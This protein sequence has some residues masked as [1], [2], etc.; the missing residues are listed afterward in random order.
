MSSREQQ[1]QVIGLCSRHL[2]SHLASPCMSH[3]KNM[4]FCSISYQQALKNFN[5]GCDLKHCGN[6][7]CFWQHPGEAWLGRQCCPPKPDG[8]SQQP[9]GKW[10]SWDSLSVQY[11][12][13]C[14][15]GQ[16]VSYF[17]H[18]IPIKTGVRVVEDWRAIHGMG[19]RPRKNSWG[20]YLTYQRGPIFQHPSVH[21]WHTHPLSTL[22][23]PDQWLGFP[24]QKL[25]TI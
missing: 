25:F 8:R 11:L 24:P 16:I 22:N 1:T 23:F 12:A 5:P 7:K 19:F 10:H 15:T 20:A 21:N 13:D 9:A 17:L 3:L 2:L 4:R 6:E 14:V 18:K